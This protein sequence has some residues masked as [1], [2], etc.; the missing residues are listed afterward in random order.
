MKYIPPYLYSSLAPVPATIGTEKDRRGIIVYD[1]SDIS[2]ITR[3]VV[4]IPRIDWYQSKIGDPQPSHIDL[5]E[6]KIYT[7]FGEKGVAVF[8]VEDAVVKYK[9]IINIPGTDKILPIHITEKGILL[10]GDYKDG[11]ITSFN[12]NKYGSI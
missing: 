12:L 2:N 4:L 9:G 3:E 8:D 5:Y 10:V 7:N 6:K 11:S 1:L